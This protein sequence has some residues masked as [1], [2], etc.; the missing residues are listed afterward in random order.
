MWQL[1]IEN[2]WLFVQRGSQQLFEN[3]INTELHSKVRFE[4]RTLAG[5]MCALLSVVYCF[6]ARNESARVNSCFAKHCSGSRTL[7]NPKTYD[8][9]FEFH[10]SL[11]RGVFV[12]IIS[13][14]VLACQR[15]ALTSCQCPS[16]IAILTG[17]WQRGATHSITPPR[18]RLDKCTHN[19]YTENQYVSHTDISYCARW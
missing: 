10:R 1:R 13:S 3:T 6:C 15:R 16:L 8:N 5:C 2:G 11:R 9:I 18:F 12:V 19:R 14:C 17:G 7:V 4:R